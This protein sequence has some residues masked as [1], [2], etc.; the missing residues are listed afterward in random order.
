[1]AAIEIFFELWIRT[2]CFVIITQDLAYILED[3]VVMSIE[4]CA[5][6]QRKIFHFTVKMSSRRPQRGTALEWF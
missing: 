2:Q 1:M 5:K 4:L 6:H 3:A